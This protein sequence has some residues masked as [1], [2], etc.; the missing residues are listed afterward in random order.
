M[1]FKEY[2]KQVKLRD[3]SKIVLR[4]VVRE[5]EQALAKFFKGLSAEDRLYL[6]DDVADPDVIHG[7]MENLDFD[8][9]LPI[10]GLDGDKII[11]DATLHRATHGWKRHVGE[12]R[13]SV[14]G[15]Y[16][17]KGLA[18]VVAAEIFQHAVSLGL[19]K[20]VAEMLA[21]QKNAQR[22]FKRLGFEEEALLKDHCM[23][24]NGKKHDLIIMSNDV[25]TLWEHWAEV[26]ET[27]SGT[28]NMED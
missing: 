5:D 10:V 21:I 23:D 22:V 6:R 24:V 9:V 7:W 27:I 17:G 11:A 28:W 13:M 2:P 25:S 16:R 18:R 1:M 20:L 14:A 19:D 3:G 26:A 15:E 4:P 12:I 8:R